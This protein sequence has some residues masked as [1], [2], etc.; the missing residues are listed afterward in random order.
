[1]G[2]P[3]KSSTKSETS[4]KMLVEVPSKNNCNELQTCAH[5]AVFQHY[6]T[7]ALCFVTA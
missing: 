2:S 3:G 6:K 7:N 4:G 1:M 5:H